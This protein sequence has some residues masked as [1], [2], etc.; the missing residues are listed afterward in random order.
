MTTFK[1]CSRSSARRDRSPVPARLDAVLDRQRDR[2]RGAA[3]AR[4]RPIPL[5]LG[6]QPRAARRLPAGDR[7]RTV[8]GALADRF[9][10]RLLAVSADLLRSAAFVGLAFAG[11]FT[12]ILA[13]ALV[14][15]IGTALYHPAA[16]SALAGLAAPH[17]DSAMGA[18][19]T[20]WSA[21]SVA[22]CGG[23]G[24]AAGALAV[25]AAA[26]RR[27]DVPDLRCHLEPVAAG[28][29]GDRTESPRRVQRRHLAIAAGSLARSA[30]RSGVG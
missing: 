25:G 21:S 13:L 15:G 30:A 3:A 6:R 29:R 5:A 10:R 23:H 20:V 18:F 4:L 16:K 9:S 12:A 19:V 27:G 28:P 11:S 22:G 2:I 7:A 26:R 14:A 8:F 1:P 24:A 17:G